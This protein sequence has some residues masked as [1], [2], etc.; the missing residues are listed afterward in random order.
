MEI[1]NSK[2]F[3]V[4]VLPEESLTPLEAAV[5]ALARDL[6]A[7]LPTPAQPGVLDPSAFCARRKLSGWNDHTNNVC[8]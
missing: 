6:H 1:P 2:A 8:F 4:F 3:Y 7:H 5:A